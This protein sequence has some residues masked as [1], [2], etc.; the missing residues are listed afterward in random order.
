[1]K[2][3]VVLALGLAGLCAV[4]LGSAGADASRPGSWTLAP[5]QTSNTSTTTSTSTAYKTMVRAPINADGSSNWPK[6]RGVIPVQFDL[7]SATKTT[8]TTTTTYGPVKF[9]SILADN[10]A[11]ELF[12]GPSPT[13]G[14]QSNDFAFLSYVPT[15]P[16][17]FS[18]LGQLQASYLF[19][20]GDCQG[21]SLRWSVRLDMT[22]NGLSP[23]DAPLYI[24]YGFPPSDS[25]CTGLSDMSGQNLLAAP[26]R[27]SLHFELTPWGGPYYGTYNQAIAL[28]G[29]LNVLRASLVL[30][31]GWVGCPDGDGNPGTYDPIAG[32]SCQNQALTPSGVTVDGN[33]FAPNSDATSSTST[34]GPFASTCNL[35][36]AAIEIVKADANPDG[37]ANESPDS[38][39]PKDSGQYF[40]NVDCKY[41]YNLDI[42]TLSGAGT[43]RVYANIGGARV[44]VSPAQFDLLP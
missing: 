3:F 27:D 16:F 36:P 32:P 12:T 22:G 29:N 40:R 21:G 6:R 4:I 9:E 44:T 1:M 30:D 41:I 7:Q 26:L 19:T 28:V 5:P 15:T 43:Y 2:R 23:D 39:Q 33:V 38:I 37:T 18:Q 11:G 34:T 20:Q 8:T 10:P 24:Y 25:P 42:S 14:T 17:P 31:S 13:Y 35:P